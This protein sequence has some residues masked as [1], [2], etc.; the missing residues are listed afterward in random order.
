M[1]IGC[2]FFLAHH[3]LVLNRQRKLL[4][5]YNGGTVFQIPPSAP[6]SPPAKP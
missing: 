2:D 4:F 5:T 3:V 6:A 1:L